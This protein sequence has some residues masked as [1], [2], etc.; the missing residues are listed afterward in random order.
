MAKV[1]CERGNG[2]IKKYYDDENVKEIIGYLNGIFPTTNQYSKMVIYQKKERGYDP[3]LKDGK[4]YNQFCSD[5]EQKYKN[6]FLDR[7]FEV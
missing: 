4:A 1:N 6:S 2:H 5:N 7:L 3:H